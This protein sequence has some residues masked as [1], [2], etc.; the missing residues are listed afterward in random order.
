MS[1]VH[2]PAAPSGPLEQQV[3]QQYAYLFQLAQTL[4]RAM[5]QA[6]GQLPAQGAQTAGKLEAQER[7]RLAAVLKSLLV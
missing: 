3:R 2:M 7:R 1:V 4:N 5:E 6:E